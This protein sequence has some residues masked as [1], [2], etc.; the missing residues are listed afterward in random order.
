MK[1]TFISSILALSII[2]LSTITT[3]AA[4]TGTVGG[5]RVSYT[6]GAT[7]LDQQFKRY[8]VADI[9]EI[10]NVYQVYGAVYSSGINYKLSDIGYTWA[11]PTKRDM[12]GIIEMPSPYTAHA[13]VQAKVISNSS[14]WQ[15]VCEW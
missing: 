7:M 3:T 15:I 12:G 1:K 6:C 11:S 10:D 2:I 5:K 9:H 8:A 14:P 13:Y 4:I